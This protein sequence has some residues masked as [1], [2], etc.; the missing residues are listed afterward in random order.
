MQRQTFAP[1]SVEWQPRP[2]DREVLYPAREARL[3]Q[4]P[5]HREADR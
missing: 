3:E 1:P 5:Q 2:G 4:Q